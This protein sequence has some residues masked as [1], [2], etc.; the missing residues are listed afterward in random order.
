M[1]WGA[2]FVQYGTHKTV[3]ARLWP[4]RADESDQ[5]SL[6]D[7]LFAR[8]RDTLDALLPIKVLLD[9]IELSKLKVASLVRN[10]A[11]SE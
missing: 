2:G 3:K 1:V 4:S 7:F 10:V 9:L 11:F 5:N 8:K 6:S